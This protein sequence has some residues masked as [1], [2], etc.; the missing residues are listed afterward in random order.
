MQKEWDDNV[1]SAKAKYKGKVVLV[2]GKISCVEERDNGLLVVDLQSDSDLADDTDY[3]LKCFFEKDQAEV[4]LK[5]VKGSWD[6]IKGE[7]VGQV[8]RRTTLVMF[9]RGRKGRPCR[10]IAIPRRYFDVTHDYVA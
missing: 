7:C 1:I 10:L 8:A 2:S 6:K 3:V 9:W 4:V 5:L